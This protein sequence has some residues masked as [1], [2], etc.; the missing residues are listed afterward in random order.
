MSASGND[1]E[2]VMLDLK[3]GFARVDREAL[4][5]AVTED[6]EWHMHWYDADD[7]QPTGR[8]LRGLDEVMAEIERRRDHWSELRYEDVE[9]RYT[10]DLIVQTFVVS[11][12]DGDGRRFNSAAVDLYP[13]RDGRI[14]RKQTY[15]KQPGSF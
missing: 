12:V 13:L 6:F 4:K 7:P 8:V 3:R 14:A 2:K 11:G 5:R 15:W 1:I 9:E 10:D